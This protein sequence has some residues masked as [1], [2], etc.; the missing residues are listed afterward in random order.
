MQ[1]S[2]PSRAPKSEPRVPC[3]NPCANYMP[4][5]PS[6]FGRGPL[7]LVAGQALNLRPLGYEPND[8]RLCGLGWPVPCY[9]W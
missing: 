7:A 1:A 5:A 6:P 9:A 8:V 3:T 4:E 2:K